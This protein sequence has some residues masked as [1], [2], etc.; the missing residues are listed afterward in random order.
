MFKESVEFVSRKFQTK[1]QWCFKNDSMKF[2]FAIL[3][4][5]GTHRSNPSRRRA[6]FDKSKAIMCY[7]NLL[8]S[9]KT[10]NNVIL[11]Y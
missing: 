5:H 8:K 1:F 10:T 11:I 3:L 4:L 6:C 7:K 2:Y 9:D